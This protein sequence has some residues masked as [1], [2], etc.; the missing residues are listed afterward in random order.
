VQAHALELL[1]DGDFSDQITNAA[2]RQEVTGKANVTFVLSAIFDRTCHKY[3]DR[4]FRYVYMEAGHVSQNI[5]LQAVSLGVGSVSV[6]A[7]SD[8][9]VNHLFG[10]D[11]HKESVIYLQAV[12]AM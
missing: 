7:F 3:G 9:K 8:D 1:K 11:G 4:G 6:G 10:L 12:G 2:L 5:S